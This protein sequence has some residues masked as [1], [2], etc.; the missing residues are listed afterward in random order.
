MTD[1]HALLEAAG[2]P[3]PYVLAGHS[4]GGLFVRLYAAAHPDE[5]AGLVLVDPSHEEQ[6]VRLQALLSAEQRAALQRATAAMTDLEGFD[7][8]ASFTQMRAARAAAPPRPMSLVVLT[9]GLTEEPPAPNW[10]VAAERQL[11]HQLHADLAGLVPNGEHVIAH[12]SGHFIHR[13]QPELV[14]TAIADVVTAAR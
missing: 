2:V 5:V 4:L 9:A 12:R 7:I 13:Q 8:G 3:G 10:P 14:I 1:L 6:E 11:R